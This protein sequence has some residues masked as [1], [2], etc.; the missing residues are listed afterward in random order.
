MKIKRKISLFY[1]S[2]T[3][4][5]ILVFFFAIDFTV[6]KYIN[7]LYQDYLLEK[8]ILTAK[9]HLEKD[10]VSESEYEAI[11]KHY[12]ETM[13]ETKEYVINIDSS[14]VLS[15]YLTP[16][17]II[18]IKQNEI[19]HFNKQGESFTAIY[20]LDNQGNFVV[21][22]A[23]YN[24]YGESIQKTL[25]Q[26][27]GIALFIS[28]FILFIIGEWYACRIFNP[29]KKVI[30]QIRNIRSHNLN[31]RI[32]YPHNDELAELTH[33]LNRMLEELNV[34]FKAQQSF[35]SNASHELMNPLT[36][37]LGECDITLSKDRSTQEYQ[38]SLRRIATETERLESLI[39]NLFIL[40]KSDLEILH[41]HLAEL[42]LTEMIGSLCTTLEKRYNIPILFHS[43]QKQCIIKCNLE[44]M[45][46]AL[47]NLIDNACKYGLGNPVSVTLHHTQ[48]NMV[49]TV[50]D[51]G[52]GIPPE[53][54]PFI[55]QSFYRAFNTSPYQGH[56]IGLSL[57]YHIIKAN[58]GTLTLKSE[59]GHYTE[60]TIVLPTTNKEF[61]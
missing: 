50:I 8:A 29:L 53:S 56:G 17:Q 42:N 3:F 26:I 11:L 13:P 61:E 12:S 4:A 10:E 44:L 38:D 59:M 34:A 33:T 46:I 57:T 49:L 9:K 39:H 21:L 51:H 60:A 5:I 2:I 16:Q 31:N 41:N 30:S 52:I 35:V 28:I 58:N 45:R 36:A 47:T 32:M 22:I 40:A 25:R 18:K 23:A 24:T 14:H 19:L 48:H 15:N 43:S 55:F 20:Y 37:I 6:N 1:L 7:M 54:L 27:L